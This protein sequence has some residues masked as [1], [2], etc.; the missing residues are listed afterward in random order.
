M[1]LLPLVTFHSTLSPSRREEEQLELDK[2][3]MYMHDANVIIITVIVD[4]V[5][6]I[7]IVVVII[8]VITIMTLIQ[9]R[10]DVRHWV[11]LNRLRRWLFNKLND[12]I[13][14]LSEHQIKSS[15]KIRKLRTKIENY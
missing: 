4:V 13:T 5:V 3:H 14:E 9:V 7:K 1:N 12:N 2:L 6:I 11:D 10:E 8:I 15:L